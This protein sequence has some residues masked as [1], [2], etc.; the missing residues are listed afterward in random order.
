MFCQYQVSQSG[1][2][3]SS[4]AAARLPMADAFAQ[5]FDLPSRLGDAP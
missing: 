2:S 3:L 4:S 5:H 1:Q